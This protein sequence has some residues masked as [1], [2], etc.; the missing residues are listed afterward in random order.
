MVS[1]NLPP[2]L[3]AENCLDLPGVSM[4]EG[5][6]PPRE[7]R[8]FKRCVCRR[9]R[10]LARVKSGGPSRIGLGLKR[11]ARDPH[12]IQITNLVALPRRSRAG[13][14]WNPLPPKS[15]ERPPQPFRQLA[16]S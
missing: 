7:S 12:A 6:K 9:L 4:R 3:L 1:G 8:Q 10:G 5:S 13:H 11:D 14:A 16:P 15:K 2:H